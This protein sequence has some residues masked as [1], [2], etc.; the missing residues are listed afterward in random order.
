MNGMAI[1]QCNIDEKVE[2][3]V[4]YISVSQNLSTTAFNF[5][6]GD[7]LDIHMIV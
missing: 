3:N 5:S 4:V 1:G 7:R 2:K 6:H